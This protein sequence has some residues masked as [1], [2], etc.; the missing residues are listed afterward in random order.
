MKKRKLSIFDGSRRGFLESSPGIKTFFLLFI[1]FIC[2]GISSQLLGQQQN[3]IALN[4]KDA[5]IK[6]ILKTLKVKANCSFVYSDVDLENLPKKSFIFEN[7]ALETVLDYCFKDTDLVYEITA[8]NVITIS[9]QK[10]VR[11][12]Q[13]CYNLWYCNR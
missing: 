12:A 4:L 5:S 6:E 3:K 10:I 8:N 9:K 11:Q 1:L 7:A 13:T 2:S